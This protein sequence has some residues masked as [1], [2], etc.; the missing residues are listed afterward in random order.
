MFSAGAN[1][2][3]SNFYYWKFNEIVKIDFGRRN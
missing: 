1:E 3:W 2:Y